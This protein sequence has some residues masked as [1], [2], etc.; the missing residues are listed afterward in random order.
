MKKILFGIAVLFSLLQPSCMDEELVGKETGTTRLS[1]TITTIDENII[2]TRAS[3]DRGSVINDVTILLL[4]NDNKFKEYAVATYSGTGNEYTGEIKSGS[5]GCLYLLANVADKIRSVGNAWKS[6]ETTL[7]DIKNSVSIDLPVAK[8]YIIADPEFSPMVSE[9]TSFAGKN[10]YELDLSRATAKVIVANTSK[11][12]KY[13]LLGANLGNA[14]TSGYVFPGNSNIGSISKANYAGTEQGTV[15]LGNMMRGV[16]TQAADCKQTEPL[17]MFEMSQ[18]QSGGDGAYVIIKGEYDGI[19]GYHRLNLWKQDKGGL[20]EYLA[21]QRNCQYKVNITKIYTQGYATA[22]DA[23][24]NPAS[25][26]DI[27][28]NIEVTDPYSRDIISN[29]E[30][31]LGVSNS[32]MVYFGEDALKN[33]TLTTVS[34]NAG[35]DVTTQCSWQVT[36]GT[37]SIS[38]SNPFQSGL[39]GSVKSTD[40][41]VTADPTVTK[42]EVLLRMGELARKIKFERKKDNIVNGGT[43][44]NAQGVVYGKVKSEDQSGNI[45]WIKMGGDS[46][47]TDLPEGSEYFGESNSGG[48]LS[49]VLDNYILLSNTKGENRNAEVILTKANEEGH[50][51]LKIT[52]K[53]LNIFEGDNSN[54]DGR[55]D[56]PYVGAFWRYNQK[57]ERVITMNAS[58]SSA[59]LKWEAQVVVGQQ[60]TRLEVGKSLDSS[61]GSVNE[62]LKSDIDYAEKF[63]LSG[64]A[65]TYI[66]GDG[67][68]LVFRIGLTSTINEQDHRYGLVLV[69]VYN[70]E[71]LVHTYRILTRQGEAPDYLFRPEDKGSGTFGEGGSKPRPLAAKFSPYNLTDPQL[72]I[73]DGSSFISSDDKLWKH[74]LMPL[75]YYEGNEFNG[76]KFT[77]YP[78]QAGY[79]FLWCVN[80]EIPENLEYMRAIHPVNNLGFTQL[81]KMGEIPSNISKKDWGEIP[82]VFDP[83]SDPCPKGYR[84]PNVGNIHTGTWS[85]TTIGESEIIQSLLY[86]PYDPLKNNSTGEDMSKFTLWGYYADGFFDRLS[87]QKKTLTIKT[88]STGSVFIRADTYA[89]NAAGMAAASGNDIGYRGQ[90]I[91]NPYNFA[92][93]F[94]PAAGRMMSSGGLLETDMYAIWAAQRDKTEPSNRG[95]Y[96]MDLEGRSTFFLVLSGQGSGNYARS[97]RCVYDETLK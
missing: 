48:D 86:A 12:A 69:N 96:P 23:I 28:V 50:T 76:D 72:G 20:G 67:S 85:T 61:I 44:Y 65:K 73:G 81:S 19:S 60:W 89:I 62:N 77:K 8:S 39:D 6:G 47:F 93:I 87:V 56:L 74:S 41:T 35:A 7:D 9:E 63:P 90:V 11:N 88:S 84:M 51:C 16:D 45:S 75:D 2:E 13:K 31:Y 17:Y 80:T 1:F 40:L 32:E 14:P 15:S 49:V 27:D 22:E 4:D 59:Q 24:K 29:G 70:R 78:S 54:Y 25:N 52:Q 94:F 42:F 91:F 83:K 71:T 21:I 36:E 58:G 79:F 92:S 43:V 10:K 26:R 18:P 5:G 57:G 53:P 46:E 30:Y 95:C 55:I 3:D 37:G 33:F 68:Q 34:F 97:V 66:S 82:L 38:C 64:D